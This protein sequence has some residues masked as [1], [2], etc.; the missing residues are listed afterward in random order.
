MFP[1][2]KHSLVVAAA[3][4]ALALVP[5]GA[6]AQ[7]D[8]R[9]PDRVA[10]P[11]V[12]QQDLRA[13]DQVSGPAVTQYQDRVQDLRAPDQ[14]AGPVQ[15]PQD[16]RAPDQVSG[17]GPSVAPST[18]SATPTPSGD[19][20]D[21]WLIVGIA[22]ATLFAAAGTGVAVVRRTSRTRAVGHA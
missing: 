15:Q 12:T 3:F 4:G 14:V 16:L 6:S 1:H 7:Q 20:A 18:P 5:A 21:V 11:A 2:S 17:P 22:L 10:G 19:G 8:L 13:P 9:A